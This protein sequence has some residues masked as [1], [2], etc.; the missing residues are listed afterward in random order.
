MPGSPARFFLDTNILVYTF[1]ETSSI[2][3]A[4]AREL[5]ELALTTRLGVV[6]HQVI[7]EFL[8]VATRKFNVPLSPADCRAYVERSS[9]RS[10]TYRPPSPSTCALSTCRSAPD[11]AFTTAS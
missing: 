3:R 6:S 2:H 4:Q 11:T 9:P 5:V 7:Q 1:D 10:G 8:N